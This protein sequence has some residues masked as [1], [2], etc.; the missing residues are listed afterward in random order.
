[1]PGRERTF[2]LLVVLLEP[3]TFR[4]ATLTAAEGVTARP[5][6][7]LVRFKLVRGDAALILL[8]RIKEPLCTVTVLTA[9]LVPGTIW[10]TITVPPLMFKVAV[11]VPP[12]GIPGVVARLRVLLT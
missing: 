3:S 5:T 4:A 7:A 8:L 1:M 12:T 11:G 10:F 2:T 9:P 6:V